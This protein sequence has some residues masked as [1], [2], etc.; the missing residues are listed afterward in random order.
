MKNSLLILFSAVLCYSCTPNVAKIDNSLKQYFDS[1]G[2]DGTFAIFNNQRGVVTVYNMKMDTLRM[3]PGSIFK[4]AE[5]LIG[6]ETSRLINEHSKIKS[7]DSS[8]TST[9]LKTAFD[10]NSN[11]YFEALARNIGLDTMRFWIDSLHYGNAEMSEVASSWQN[12]ELKISSD[13]QL[14]LVT[15]LYFDKLSFQ[16]YAQQVLRDLLLKEDNTLFKFSYTTGSS[17]DDHTPIG[18]TTG[19][20]EENRHVYLFSCA[21]RAKPGDA[22]PGKTA[23]AVTKK[24]LVARGFFQGKN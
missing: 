12:G 5:T 2:V 18:W 9:T 8:I 11:A 24:I 14:G 21:I 10:Q 4:I 1:E 3:S 15:R 6:V 7:P 17:V 13:E 22:D 19:W 20:V 23:F 16:K